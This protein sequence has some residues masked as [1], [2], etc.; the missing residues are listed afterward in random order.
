MADTIYLLNAST[1]WL[2]I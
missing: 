1:D 2:R